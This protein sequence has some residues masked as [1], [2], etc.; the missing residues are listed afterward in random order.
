MSTKKFENLTGFV[1]SDT[2]ETLATEFINGYGNSN[3]STRL[4]EKPFEDHYNT[5]L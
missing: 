4:N 1:F 5:F 3:L 2:T